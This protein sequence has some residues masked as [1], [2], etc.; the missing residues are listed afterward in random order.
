M[1]TKP[2]SNLTIHI[3]DDGTATLSAADW[4]AEEQLWAIE[5]RPVTLAQV[6]EVA[7]IL[8]PDAVEG[9]EARIVAT[10]D[11][12]VGRVGTEQAALERVRLAREALARFDE[13]SQ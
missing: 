12:L 13:A 9:V 10:R 5:A 2:V 6:R 7:A 8:G 11:R 1:S 4:S 3:L